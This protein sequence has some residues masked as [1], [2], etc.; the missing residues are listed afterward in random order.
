MTPTAIRASRRAARSRSAWHHRRGK[1]DR[2]GQPESRGAGADRRVGAD[3]AAMHRCEA[4][5]AD[6]NRVVPHGARSRRRWPRGSPAPS[7]RIVP[8][9]RPSHRRQEQGRQW[10]VISRA[11]ASGRGSDADQVDDG[12]GGG[13]PGEQHGLSSRRSLSSLLRMTWPQDDRLGTRWTA[14]CPISARSSKNHPRSA[15]SPR[16]STS[17]SS[18]TL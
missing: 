13:K 3:M 2:D 6:Q 17:R 16:R 5:R 10:L 4:E 18:T 1:R 8:P 14:P 15:R 11:G 9:P 12:R 7:H